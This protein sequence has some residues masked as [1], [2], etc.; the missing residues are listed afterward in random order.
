MWFG[1]AIMLLCFDMMPN[2]KGLSIVRHRQSGI[3]CGARRK[4]MIGESGR[5][6]IMEKLEA[7]FTVAEF[8]RIFHYGENNGDGGSSLEMHQKILEEQRLYQ[9]TQ[10]YKLPVMLI[11]C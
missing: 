6:S 7:I 1:I 4:Y 3:Q 2:A 9:I 11:L 10:I 8:P 5:F